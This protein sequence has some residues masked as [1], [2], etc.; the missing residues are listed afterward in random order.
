MSDCVNFYT[1]I[2]MKD[3]I[4]IPAAPKVVCLDSRTG[5]PAIP[6]KVHPITGDPL[7]KDGH[8]IHPKGPPVKRRYPEP[9]Y[10]AGMVA[11]AKALAAGKIRPGRD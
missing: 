10:A 3:E 8:V 2:V 1:L 9:D 11:A 4:P 6:L 5:L 7:D